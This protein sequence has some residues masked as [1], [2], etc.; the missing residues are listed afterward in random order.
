MNKLISQIFVSS[1]LLIMGTALGVWGSRQLATL[2][3][4]SVSDTI[5]P[6]TSLQPVANSVFPPF[7]QSSPQKQGNFNFI[8]EVAQK[9][10]PA[11]VRIEAT[12]QVSFNNSENFEYPL[13][14]HFFPEQIPFERTERGT[15]SGFI[16][17]D[18]GLIMTNAHVVE[19]TSFVSVLLPSGKTYEGRVLGIDSMTD[20]AVVKIT[21][22]NLPTVILG[23]AKNLIIGEWA[24][25]IGNPLGLD[26]TVTVGIISAKDRFSSEVGVPDKRVKFIQ[27]DAAINPGNSGGPLLNARGEVIGI[28]TAIRA[29]AQGLGFAIPIETASRIAEQLYTTGKASH[30]YIGIQMI[31]LNQ[32]TIKNDNIPQN[33]GFENVPEKGVLVVKV[34]ENSPAS[35][36]G[37]LP[38]DVINNVN[39]IEVLTAQDVQ[40]QVEIS[41]IGEVI[42]IRIDRQGKFI[43]LKVYPAEFPI[44]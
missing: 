35:Q 21:A 33:L 16:V 14:K 2:N 26:N 40:E 8:S 6:E 19:G 20:V 4:S 3:Q 43:T 36:A 29:D 34:M 37:F 22:E 31:T 10:G 32:D 23:K 13:F 11:V 28:N 41:T 44:E 24:I 12:R 39:N 38:G 7:K 5:P 42:P 30:P 15:G 9:V 17:S 25:A 27:T 1:S 18:D